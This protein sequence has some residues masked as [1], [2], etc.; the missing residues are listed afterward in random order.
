MLS[1]VF[2][3][4]WDPG[5]KD[6]LKRTHESLA[7]VEWGRTTQVVMK[8]LRSQTVWQTVWQTVAETKLLKSFA[9]A[10]KIVLCRVE[11]G[12]ANEHGAHG[13]RRCARWSRGTIM[14]V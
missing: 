2:V 13:R 10:V 11:C 9:R 12:V 6:T 14:W 4:L 3:G 1:T 5:M 7:N 8:V